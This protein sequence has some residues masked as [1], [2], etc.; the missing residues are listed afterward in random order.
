MVT[1]PTKYLEQKKK[2][3]RPNSL[4]AYSVRNKEII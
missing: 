3:E 4:K 2:I 1:W